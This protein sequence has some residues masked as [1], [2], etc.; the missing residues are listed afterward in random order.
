MEGH[1]NQVYSCYVLFKSNFKIDKKANI[2]PPQKPFACGTSSKTVI[3]PRRT[4]GR[5][6]SP[7]A[8]RYLEESS[9]FRSVVR[10]IH[11][12]YPYHLSGKRIVDLGCFE[13]GY[14]VGFARLG[15]NALGIEARQ[16]NYDNCEFVRRNLAL[17]NLAFAHDD[18]W[19]CDRYGD[20][21]IIFCSGLLYHLDEPKRFIRMIASI[22]KRLLILNTHVALDRQNKKFPL[23]EITVHEGLRGRWFHEYAAGIDDT[24]K[25][26]LKWSA[27]SNPTSFWPTAP[28]L[29]AALRDAGYSLVFE[30]FD[31]MREI[32]HEMVAGYYA[33]DD[34]RVFIAVKN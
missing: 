17:P 18:A 9:I 13:G 14:T 10:S 22:N 31:W 32:E 28:C 12:F 15:M 4:A 29:L 34:R 19:N 21:D 2:K 25:E 6:G 27:W 5:A 3:L 23:G 26:A 16:N 11:A 1:A 7:Q 8:E 30:Q 20:F 33:N 24:E